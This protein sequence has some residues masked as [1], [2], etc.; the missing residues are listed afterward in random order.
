MI[1]LEAWYSAR[2]QSMLGSKKPSTTLFVLATVRSA[3]ALI[4]REYTC[5]SSLPVTTSH[6]GSGGKP[7]SRVI[8][9]NAASAS[10]FA[11]LSAS[12]DL[13]TPGK[14]KHSTRTAATSTIA[15]MPKDPRRGTPA[16]GISQSTARGGMK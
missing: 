11:G 9:A 14:R 7:I 8:S 2:G 4:N 3:S 12:P 10:L 15:V 1:R 6:N 5:C 16:V 13:S